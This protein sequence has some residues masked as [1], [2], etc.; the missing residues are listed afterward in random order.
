MVSTDLAELR[1]KVSEEVREAKALEMT[2]ERF[3]SVELQAAALALETFEKTYSLVIPD[4]VALD[5]AVGDIMSYV[6]HHSLSLLSVFSL[7]T[8]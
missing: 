6:T 8:R 1:R 4:R 7:H 3:I 2:F 5:E